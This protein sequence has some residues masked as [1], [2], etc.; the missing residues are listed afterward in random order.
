MTALDNLKDVWKNQ[1]ANKIQFSETDIYK[2]IHKKSASIV[3]WIFYISVIEFLIFI[4]PTLFL[5]TSEVENELGLKTFVKVLSIIN[6]GL[7]MPIFMY[8]FYRNYKAICVQDST[9]KLMKDILKTKK[10]V[11]YYVLS[12]MLIIVTLLITIFYELFKSD[13]FLEQLPENVSMNKIWIIAV[14]I[15]IFVLLVVWVFYK[16]LYGILL[17]KLKFNYKELL[18]NEHYS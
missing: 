6:Y 13:D 2:M 16:L 4:L 15:V 7:I 14:L 17:H 18:K 10:T 3:K 11:S 1:E 8:L 12:Q 5:D 9:Q